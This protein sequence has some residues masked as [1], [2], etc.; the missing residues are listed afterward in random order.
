MNQTTGHADVRSRTT[1]GGRLHFA[2][3]FLGLTALLAL[4]AGVVYASTLVPEWGRWNLGTLRE[5]IRGDLGEGGRVAGWVIAVS[6]AVVAAA[7]VVE[8]LATVVFSA[9]RRSVAGTMAGVQVVLA[10]AL[11]AGVNAFSFSHYGRYDLTRDAQFTLPENVAAELKKLR[12]PTTIVVLQQHKT[13]GRLADRPDVYDYAA[14]RKVVEKVHDLVGQLRELGPQFRVVVLDVEQEGYDRKLRE[15]TEGKP[16][17]RRAIDAAPENS[18]FFH[19]NGNVQRLSFNEFYQLD[20]TASKEAD[21]GRGNLVLLPQGVGAFVQKILAVEQRKPV[22]GVAVIHEW[23]TTRVAEGQEQFTLA[24]LRKTLESYGFEVRDIV[25]KKNWDTAPRPEPAAYTYEES[26]LEALEEELAVVADELAREREDLQGTRG[27]VEDLRKLSPQELNER[28]PLALGRR[29]TEELQRQVRQRYEESL[30]RIASRIE[31]LEK[32][33]RRLEGE[34]QQL[35][36]E[37]RAVEE[38]RLTDV[39]AKLRRLLSECDL[40][41]LP[42]MTLI[43]ATL[44]SGI[45]PDLYDLSDDQA[46]AVREFLKAGKPLLACFGPVNFTSDRGGLTNYPGEPPAE[47]ADGVER[48]LEQLGIG[49]GK[50]TVLLDAETRAIAERR[51]GRALGGPAVEIP[52]LEV[53]AKP[54]E[55]ASG[56]VAPNPIGQSLRVMAR[57][58]GRALDLTLR[59]PRP[60]YLDPAREGDMPFAAEFLFTPPDSW[61]EARPFMEAE[62]RQ[63][64]GTPFAQVVVSY[65]PR[66]ERTPLDSPKRGTP[67]EERRGPFPVGV[68]VEVKPPVEWFDEKYAGWKAL[69]GLTGPAGAAGLLAAGLTASA[70]QVERPTT[71]V[72]V[73]GHGGLFVGPDLKPAQQD[74]L[75]TTCNWLLGREDRLPTDAAGEPWSYPRLAMTDQEKALWHW[76]TFLGLPAVC[77]YLGLVVLMVRRVR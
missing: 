36:E 46:E 20:K 75:L 60:V 41:V 35:Y 58:A 38:R 12:A 15:L 64:P 31:E 67:E 22:V 39:K 40:L 23:L 13:F 68:A 5:A 11:L 18:I 30:P 2:V 63:I 19:A 3:R 51:A 53:R 55:E 27:L 14:E 66:F 74:L 54:A 29:W 45:P 77:A 62:T 59:N 10:A 44:G 6:A 43:N 9:G 48:L 28:R 73:Y 70:A 1:W 8:L 33:Q 76:A 57:S 25:L 56:D 49:L 61:N 16:E 52:P 26:K 21:G 37:E 72:V 7:L 47:P 34:L 32:E 4:A 65:M 24:G 42:R 71:R 69:S 17:L 50:Q